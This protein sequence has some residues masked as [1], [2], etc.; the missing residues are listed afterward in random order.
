MPGVPWFWNDWG[1][2]NKCSLQAASPLY[3]SFNLFLRQNWLNKYGKNS[4]TYIPSATDSSTSTT[5]TTN[6]TNSENNENEI[7]LVIEVRNINKMKTNNQSSARFIKNLSELIASL[8]NIPNLKITAQD[9]SKLKFEQQVQLSNSAQILMSMHGAGTTHIFH[10]PIG[11]KKCC[12][13]IELFPDQT[14]EFYQ[15]Y[16]YGN[17]ARML[18][19]IH[20]R[21]VAAM[22]STSSSGTNVNINEIKI[23]VEKAIKEI[24]NKQT[25]TCLNDVKDTTQSLY[26]KNYFN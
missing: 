17:L 18:G 5:I 14:I 25:M 23:L 8:S 22:G 15:A 24:T 10:M 26:S 16:G 19:L 3:Q 6:S 21:Y 9:F 12:S 13:L 1:I 7:H 20:Y 4:L 2:I 11:T